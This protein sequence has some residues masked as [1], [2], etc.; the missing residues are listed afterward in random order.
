MLEESM[1]AQKLGLHPD[2]HVVT[3]NWT[4]RSRK[5][6]KIT[7]LLI[8]HFFARSMFFKKGH[9]LASSIYKSTKRVK[10]RQNI[11]NLGQESA[12]KSLVPGIAALV[13]YFT[14]FL[15]GP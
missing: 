9:F 5:I 3:L 15:V 7:I 2:F 14:I 11:E 12:R 1:T 4:F 8:D 6:L 13:W 10:P